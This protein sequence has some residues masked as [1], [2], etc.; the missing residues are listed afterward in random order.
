MHCKLSLLQRAEY[1]LMSFHF[2]QFYED[3]KALY[4]VSYIG[5]SMCIFGEVFRKLA[6]YTAGK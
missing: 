1:A 3:F 5:L 6:M 4:T 2:V